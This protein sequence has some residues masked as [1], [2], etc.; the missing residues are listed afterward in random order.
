MTFSFRDEENATFRG[1][2]LSRGN[3]SLVGNYSPDD[4]KMYLEPLNV[5]PCK[6]I[7]REE[8]PPFKWL[9]IRQQS[10]RFFLN[11]H[12]HLLLIYVYHS[13]VETTFTETQIAKT[14]CSWH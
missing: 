6:L 1:P 12:L 11:K 13:C 2:Y 7:L 8:T 5:L 9:L 10:L 3:R 14:I 4:P